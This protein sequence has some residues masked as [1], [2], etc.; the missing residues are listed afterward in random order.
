MAYTTQLI[1]YAFSC[2][3]CFVLLGHPLVNCILPLQIYHLRTHLL[4]APLHTFSILLDQGFTPSHM[5]LA[6]LQNILYHNVHAF[7][8]FHYAQGRLCTTIR[9]LGGEE[10]SKAKARG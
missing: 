4:H 10:K 1:D 6:H 9:L 7:W 8:W 2:K 5:C 3:Y